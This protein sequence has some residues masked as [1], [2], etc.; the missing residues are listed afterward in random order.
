MTRATEHQCRTLDADFTRLTIIF[1][2]QNSAIVSTNLS[3]SLGMAKDN[4][5]KWW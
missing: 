5:S 4:I 3:I 1:D 2:E